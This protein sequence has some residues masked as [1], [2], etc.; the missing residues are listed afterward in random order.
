MSGV[1]LGRRP[2]VLVVDLQRAFTEDP[3]STPG[4]EETLLNTARLLDRA[5][6]LG[7]PVFYVH[8]VYEDPFEVGPVWASKVPPM[9]SCLA[10]SGAVELHPLVAPRP[11]DRVLRKKRASAFFGTSLHAELQDLGVDSLIV[12]GTSTSGCVRASVV[13][14]AQLDYRVTVVEDCVEDRSSA[15]HQT[16][17]TDMQA[18][19]ADVTNLDILLE[20]LGSTE[21]KAAATARGSRAAR[22]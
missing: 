8:V 9:A 13:D 18:K 1:G 4:T 11:G 16:S 10:G 19:Y 21:R 20:G 17:L 14:A 6:D 2:A 22:A 5:R 12:A 7:L 3:L 15:S